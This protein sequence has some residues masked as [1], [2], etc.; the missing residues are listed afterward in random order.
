MTRSRWL[1]LGVVLL[2]LLGGAIG[3]AAGSLRP[4]PLRAL[5]HY[6]I[7]LLIEEASVMSDCAECHDTGAF[8]RCSSCHDEHGS[9]VLKGFPFYAVVAFEGD[10]PA[11]GYV[12][13]N[14]VVPYVDH[15]NTYVSLLEFLADRGVE[16]FESVTLASDD[17]GFV[18]ITFENLTDTAWLLP[19]Q[20]GI[21][22]ASE[23]LHVST[24]LKGIRRIV[25]VGRDRPLVIE[26]QATSMGRLLLGPVQQVTV[27]KTDVMLASA[28]DGEV[29]RAQ[30][31][32][33]VR[34]VQLDTIVLGPDFTT[35]LIRTADGVEVTVTAEEARGGILVQVRGQVTLVFPDRGRAQWVSNVVALESE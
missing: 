24:W 1:V 11:P 34:G 33:R 2:M 6:P 7:D 23:D 3:V 16:D 27:E 25:V 31:G 18:T 14:D 5:T 8:H 9:A 22:F 30:V 32:S 21:R 26:G 28:Q 20:D 12:L 13:V 17:G 19:F 35:L 29:R 15:P 4:A 10:V